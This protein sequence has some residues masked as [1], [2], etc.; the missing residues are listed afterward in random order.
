MIELQINDRTFCVDYTFTR[1]GSIEDLAL[2][3]KCKNGKLLG[4]DM[5]RISGNMIDRIESI[6]LEHEKELKMNPDGD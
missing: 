4:I 6:I 3:Y 5:S 2:S 1:C